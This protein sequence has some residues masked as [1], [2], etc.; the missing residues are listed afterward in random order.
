M[1]KRKIYISLIF[2]FLLCAIVVGAC[3]CNSVDNDK[4]NDTTVQPTEKPSDNN[5]AADNN[6]DKNEAIEGADDA[7]DNTEKATDEKVTDTID[8]NKE[9][10]NSAQQDILVYLYPEYFGIDTSNGLDI[11]VWQLAKDHYGFGLLPHATDEKNWLDEDLLELKGVSVDTMREILAS[12]DLEGV[13]VYITPWQNPISSYISNYFVLG[14]KG[15]EKYIE[16][17][18]K[19]LF[20]VEKNELIPEPTEPNYELKEIES[21]VLDTKGYGVAEALETFYQ[22]A[23][24]WYYFSSMVSKYITVTYKDT[25][26]ENIKDALANRHIKISDLDRFGIEYFKTES[27]LKGIVDTTE[28]AD[29]AIERFY[30]DGQYI[31]QFSQVISQN[32]TV[33]YKDG[34][35]ENVKDALKN[36]RIMITALDWYGIDYRKTEKVKKLTLADVKSLASRYGEELTWKHFEDFYYV[37]GGSGL[38]IRIYPIDHNYQLWIGGGN[39]DVTPVYI[40]LK[41]QDSTGDHIDV[42]T[43]NIDDFLD[44]SEYLI[45]VPEDFSFSLTWGIYGTHSYDSSTGILVK[46]NQVTPA[47]DYVTT[48]TLNAWEREY[49]YRLLMALNVEKYP[50]EYTPSMY[51]SE[52]SKTIILTLRIGDEEKTINARFVSVSYD[53]KDA[54]GKAFLDTCNTIS[55]ILEATEAWNSLPYYDHFWE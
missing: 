39:P 47:E 35:S 23:E 6:I 22:D 45:D 32:I 38:Y 16:N 20:E 7:T 48:Y 8:Q 53:Y 29:D 9:P 4:V 33:Y 52:P 25:S 11:Y 3:G 51:P 50:D 19:M 46:D 34:T 31:Y 18:R 21:I 10:Q 54:A 43:E 12:Y 30:E 36:G 40:Y 1:K 41:E 14:P 2:V 49:I 44:S 28:S 24:Y 55:D 37:E 26:T 27:D 15:Q 5:A 17:V 13:E 42:R